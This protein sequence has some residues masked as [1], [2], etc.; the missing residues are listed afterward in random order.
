MNASICRINWGFVQFESLDFSSTRHNLD[1]TP[2]SFDKIDSKT[3]NVII[4]RKLNQFMDHR[5]QKEIDKNS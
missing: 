3:G 5:S 2:V 4:K 1:L